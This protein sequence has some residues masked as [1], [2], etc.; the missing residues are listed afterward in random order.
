M[1]IQY[2]L[3]MNFNQ[4]KMKPRTGKIFSRTGGWEP[5]L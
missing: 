1:L 5:L 4:V 2:N 3:K